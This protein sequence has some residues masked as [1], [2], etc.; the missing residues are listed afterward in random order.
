MPTV[1]D[2]LK[3]AVTLAE[4]IEKLQAELNQILNGVGV[5]NALVAQP[6][7]TTTSPAAKRGPKKGGMSAA[8][9]AAIIAAQKARWAKVKAAKAGSASAQSTA[10]PKKKGKRTFS[11]EAKAKMAEAARKRWAKVKKAKA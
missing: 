4:Q 11:P 9:R 1:I 8:G 10:A 7:Q 3:R 2:S 5:G 6:A